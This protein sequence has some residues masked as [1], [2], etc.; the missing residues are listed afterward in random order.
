MKYMIRNFSEL[1]RSKAHENALKILEAGL[2]AA[3]PATAIKSKVK[4]HGTTLFVG[5]SAYD[6]SRGVK[7]V[8]IGKASAT[9]AKAVE[10]IL[11]DL[12]V[13]GAVIIPKGFKAPSLRRVKVLYGS[14]PLPDVST[15]EASSEVLNLCRYSREGDV[16]IV[17]ISGGGSALFELPQEPITIDDLISTTSLLLKCGADIKEINTVRKHISKVKGGRLA[18][19]LHPAKVITLILSDVVGDPVEFIAS[20]PTAPDTTTYADAV[21][22]L[23]RYLIWDKVPNS[24][25]QVLLSGLRGELPETPKPGDAVFNNVNNLIVASNYLSLK[26]MESEAR[27]LGYNTLVVTSMM[28]GEAR[29]VGKFISGMVRHVKQYDEPVRRPAALLLGGETT[30]TVRGRGVGGRNQELAL[31]VA[32]GISGVSGVV[33]ASIGS[34]GIDGVTDAAGAIVDGSTISEGRVAGLD[35]YEI[36]SNNDSYTFLK[37]V[38]SLIFTGPTGT[39]VNDLAL[40]IVE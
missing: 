10:D 19:I 37:A 6:V 28:E 34:D 12:I 36:L 33:F 29:E 26:A 3:D 14:H 32:I 2:A 35:P 15:L 17:L 11:G 22:V 23:K 8:G 7:V 39:N 24:V 27:S 1:A 13:D 40:A 30:V 18:E 38:K 21:S 16:F 9:M 4:L 20:G 31:S 5:N 25:R